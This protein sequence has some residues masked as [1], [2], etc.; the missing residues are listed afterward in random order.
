S[1]RV[2]VGIRPPR[3]LD[4]DSQMQIDVLRGGQ[5]ALL[6]ELTRYLD[7][8]SVELDDKPLEFIHNQALEGSQLARRGNDLIAVVFPQM[9]VAGQKIKLR[10]KYGGEVISEAGSG[11]LYVGA[12]GTWYPNIGLAM[13]NFDLEF[14]YPAAWTLVATGKPATFGKSLTQD[15]AILT[16]GDQ[17][18][19]WRSERP[20]PVAG[21]NLGKYERA[22]ATS[23]L[24][25]V[26]AYATAVVEKNFPKTSEELISIPDVRRPDVPA[27]TVV[28]TRPPPSPARNAQSVANRSAQAVGFFSKCFGPYPY[29][30]LAL[31]QLPGDLSQGWP[32]L[33][34]L[35]SYAFLTDADRQHL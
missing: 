8:R 21:F 18:N 22:G 14:H 12:R 6:F 25:V 13:S 17:A 23:G 35:S 29:S 4:A 19:R 24:I 16:A 31:T 2:A 3:Q 11:L 7:V 9:L 10:F 1:Y 5:R 30:S 33:V 15:L 26:E 27:G 20:I 34:F 32:G 28:V